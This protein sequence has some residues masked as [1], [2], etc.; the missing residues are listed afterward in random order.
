MGNGKNQDNLCEI[1]LTELF[2]KHLLRASGNK[3]HVLAAPVFIG[4]ARMFLLMVTNWLRLPP[5]R[6]CK[7]GLVLVVKNN[8]T[9]SFLSQG[10]RFHLD[11]KRPPCDFSI[12]MTMNILILP[13]SRFCMVRRDLLRRV[14]G[15]LWLRLFL[16][17]CMELPFNRF[18]FDFIQ[19]E[20]GVQIGYLNEGVSCIHKNLAVFYAYGMPTLPNT[21]PWSG[22]DVSLYRAAHTFIL[23]YKGRYF[24]KNSLFFY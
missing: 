3:I 24:L 18:S 9:R 6:S 7:H 10:G 15:S 20:I 21:F 16:A 12:W 8:R 5:L 19:L 4:G 11:V 17:Y 14:A 1:I 22:W 13:L 23:L 2:K